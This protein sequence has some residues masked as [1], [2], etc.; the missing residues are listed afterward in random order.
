MTLISIIQW[1]EQSNL[2]F[3]ILRVEEKIRENLGQ[4]SIITPKSFAF[5]FLIFVTKLHKESDLSQ[6]EWND[7][8][9]GWKILK[10]APQKPSLV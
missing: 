5:V 8:G 9:G 4:Y 3:N 10:N 7:V 2:Q 1:E 6:G